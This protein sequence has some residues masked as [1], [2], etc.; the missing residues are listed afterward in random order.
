MSLSKIARPLVLLTM[1][2]VGVLGTANKSFAGIVFTADSNN[3]QQKI[4]MDKA[5]NT[6]LT[7]N[8]GTKLTGPEVYFSG[9]DPL[10]PG[11]VVLSSAN[12]F[13]Q[14]SA[15]KP[16]ATNLRT[17]TLTTEAGLGISAMNWSLYGE[18]GSSGSLTFIA[19]D[20]SNQIIGT[21][22][23]FAFDGN[24]RT[25]FN[26]TTDAG[27]LVSKLEILS[28]GKDIGELKQITLNSPDIQSVPEPT[29]TLAFAG[30]AAMCGFYRL[31]RRNRKAER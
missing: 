9:F 13:A 20:A 31:R 15:D 1:L 26:F 7:G 2:T 6:V 29:S 23:P 5:T 19:Y 10:K 28:T 24:G 30:V 4:F 16:K 17:L 25:R 11:S 21:S 8:A 22:S 18:D 27:S 14:I 3:Y 12:G